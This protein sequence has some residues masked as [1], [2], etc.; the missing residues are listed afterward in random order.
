ML[1]DNDL[2]SIVT[3]A[4]VESGGNT[5]QIVARDPQ[6]A[7]LV[8]VS[9]QAASFSG[10]GSRRARSRSFDWTPEEDQFVRDNL[11]HLSDEEIGAVLGR[12][13]DGVHIRRERCLRLLPRGNQPDEMTANQIAEG[14]GVDCKSVDHLIDS[15]ILPGRRLPFD[16]VF[17]VVKRVALLGW[18]VNWRNWVYF[19]PLRVGKRG[20]RRTKH[21]Y[22]YEFWGHARR[23]VLRAYERWG[24][25]WWT[26]G[27]V[28]DCRGISIA[29]VNNAVHDGRLP[30]AIK[31]QNWRILK[32]VAVAAKRLHTGKGSNV[33]RE[34]S[35]GLDELI[36]LGTAVGLS[37]NTLAAYSGLRTQAICYRRR[38]LQRKKLIKPLIEQRGLAV[39]YNARTGVLFAD[40]K[41]YRKRFKALAEAMDKFKRG[42]KLDRRELGY[43]RGVLHAWCERFYH[44]RDRADLLGKLYTVGNTTASRLRGLYGQLLRA[45]IDPYRM[46][47]P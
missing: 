28:A 14:L 36:V 31:W 22:D 21:K 23:L 42:D 13:A 35:A 15:G 10:D 11:T 16:A 19:D 5:A 3:Q 41:Q 27:Q 17:R 43:V 18:L 9:K 26:P 45:G 20:P 4:L 12:S 29:T 39:D 8:I 7:R 38:E 33:Y 46:K 32:S 2:N 1:T 44:R 40:W 24:D 6:A 30:G 34:Y 25:E 47:N 37:V